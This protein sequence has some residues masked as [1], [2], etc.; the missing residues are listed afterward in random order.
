M[1]ACTHNDE[2]HTGVVITVQN[3]KQVCDLLVIM[4]V[5]GNPVVNFV[6]DMGCVQAYV[7]LFTVFQVVKIVTHISTYA[8]M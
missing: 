6:Y 5:L 3:N 7:F 1:W 2:T 8:H 4:F